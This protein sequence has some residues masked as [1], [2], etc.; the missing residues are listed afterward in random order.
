MSNPEQI[1]L[2]ELINNAMTNNVLAIESCKNTLAQN[3]NIV[4]KNLTDAVNSLVKEKTELQVEI[5]QLKKQIDKPK[6]EEQSVKV[7]QLE[8]IS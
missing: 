1:T 8:K 3:F 6:V 5:V 4:V 2:D 7:A